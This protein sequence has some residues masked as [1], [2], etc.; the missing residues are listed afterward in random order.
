MARTPSAVEVA[1]LSRDDWEA[2][3]RALAALIYQAEGV[4]DRR[5]KGNGLDMIRVELEGTRGWQFRRFDDRF[6]DVQATKILDSLALAA[7]RVAEE[8][9]SVLTRFS[10]WA[11]IDLEPGHG[12]KMGERERFAKLKERAKKEYNV[13]LDFV[14][15]TWVRAQLLERPKL[16]P[17]LFENVSEQLSAVEQSLAAKIDAGNAVLASLLTAAGAA[18]AALARIVEQAKV[19]FERGLEHGSDEQFLAAATCLRDAHNLVR[20]MSV[21]AALEGKILVSL[22]AVELR[23][24]HLRES[25]THAREALQLLPSDQ[26]E[27]I[28]HAKGNLASALSAREQFDEANTLLR[29]VLETF[30]S[31]GN[32]VEIV[33]TLTHLLE[34]E[35][36]RRNLGGV[37]LW[38]RRLQLAVHVLP[39]SLGHSKLSLA[40]FGAFGRAL[41]LL[42]MSRSSIEFLKRAEQ[43]FVVVE[44]I[45]QKAGSAHITITALTQRAEAVRYQDRLAEA[46]ALYRQAIE[47]S[48]AVHMAKLSAD[49][50]YNL[51]I[52]YHEMN[53]LPIALQTMAD[54]RRRYESIGD[55]L[56]VRDA[57]RSIDAWSRGERP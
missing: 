24:G 52:I 22:S 28:G 36:N 51:A 29:E 5:G 49:S 47:K 50:T 54:A 8:D 27:A 34:L 4:E 19:H 2:L 53:R 38:L 35:I 32:A 23:L 9:N 6:G 55:T 26:T 15:V 14:G 7:R 25:E 17:A 31:A 30:E 20:G 13:E 40:A 3:C 48:D 56:S 42:G 43:A 45:A 12:G 1:A 39:D 37:V 44:A 18:S 10:I 41:L 33:R 46:E 21:D 11:N 16:C 57:R